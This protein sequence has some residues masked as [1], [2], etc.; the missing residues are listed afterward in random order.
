MLQL[1]PTPAEIQYVQQAE[2]Q[3]QS[4]SN[5]LAAAWAGSVGGAS[6]AVTSFGANPMP[7][8]GT[9]IDAVPAPKQQ[10]QPRQQSKPIEEE[11]EDFDWGGAAAGA[12]TQGAQYSLLGAKLG[13][14]VPGLGTTAGA[15]GGAGLGII[16]GGLQGGNS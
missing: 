11:D 9:G 4:A 1:G 12:A 5:Q 3:R 14:V 13:S 8:L 7:F 10:A 6:T 15:I 2:A 16:L